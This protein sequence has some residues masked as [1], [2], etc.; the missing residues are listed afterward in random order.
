MP[1]F[2]TYYQMVLTF[3]LSTTSPADKYF[4]ILSV[5]G[6]AVFSIGSLFFFFCVENKSKITNKQCTTTI[7]ESKYNENSAGYIDVDANTGSKETPMIFTNRNFQNS[8]TSSIPPSHNNT[9]FS[10]T[11]RQR[12]KEEMLVEEIDY[13]I[14]HREDFYS[15]GYLFSIKRLE[16]HIKLPPELKFKSLLHFLRS[17]P[18]FKVK[19][20]FNEFELVFLT[21]FRV[22][23]TPVYGEFKCISMNC[24]HTW[25]TY[26]SYC[27]TSEQCCK[28]KRFVFPYEQRLMKTLTDD[29]TI[30]DRND[31]FLTRVIVIIII[32]L[33]III[34]KI[35]IKIIKIINII[36]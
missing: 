26:T 36:N 16:E 1:H 5:S 6:V 22:V 32:L 20:N 23:N 2:N 30:N 14:R 12:Y 35:I 33:I 8:L 11:K 31:R 13:F 10:P 18:E 9:N 17:R 28:C 4:A 3:W 19:T 15:P 29:S 34:I 21:P 27:D 25:S 24:R 7:S